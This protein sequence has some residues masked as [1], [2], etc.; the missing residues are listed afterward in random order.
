M[1]SQLGV[2]DRA[3]LARSG[4]TPMPAEEGLRLFDLALALGDPVLVPVRLDTATLRNRAA[5]GQDV[6]PLLRGLVPMTAAAAGRQTGEAAAEWVQRLAGLS[7]TARDEALLELVRTEAAAVL[8]HGGPAD[9]DPDRGFLELGFDSLTAVELRNTLNTVT[10]LR[11]PATLL[12]DYPSP[13]ALA[14]YLGGE[15]PAG[16]TG[17]V[18]ALADFDQLEAVLAA[19]ANLGDGLPVEDRSRVAARLEALAAAWRAA[20]ETDRDEADDDLGSATADEMFALIDQE[21]GLS[22]GE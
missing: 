4:V 19:A 8:G 10:G 5:A 16:G 15:L 18:P 12:F 11:L 14:R 3:R 1:S 17:P 6:P 22:H 13:V 21:F 20:P 7:G 9:V 2:A